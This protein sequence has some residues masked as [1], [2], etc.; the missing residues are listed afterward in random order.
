VALGERGLLV[1]GLALSL[2]TSKVA[3]ALC[4]GDCNQD[5]QVTIDEIIT[6]VNNALSSCPQSPMR[7]V[8]NHDGTITD[9][10]TRLVWEKKTTDGSI[11]DVNNIYSWSAVGPNPDGSG[12]GSHPD[13][14]VFTTFLYGLNGG[15][16]FF[17]TSTS[18]CFT[19]RCD[20]RLPTIEELQGILLSPY[21]CSTSPCIDS[22]FGPT[23]ANSYWSVTTFSNSSDR[24]WVVNFVEGIVEYGSKGSSTFA[25][26]VRGG[27]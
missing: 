27:L 9:I 26:A 13:G 10:T 14:T 19:G 5:G 4:C 20:W 8:D 12:G 11:H 15:I 22:A 1:L 16:S 18:G 7:F 2:A 23:F 17:G 21:P 25:R 3:S 24:V 6:A